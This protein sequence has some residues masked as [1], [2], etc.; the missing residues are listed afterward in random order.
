M[1]PEIKQQISD[2]KK[3]LRLAMN[4]IVSAHQRKQ[5]LDYKINFGVEI[6]RLKDIARRYEKDKE[7][8][9]TLWCDNIR[10]CKMLAIFLM[11]QEEFTTNE[12]EEWIASIRY[13][14]LADHLVMCLLSS[15][16]D[17]AENALQWIERDNGLFPYCGFLLLSHT[18]RKG[19][20]LAVEQEK[21]YLG[22]ITKALGTKNPVSRNIQSVAY[23]SLMQYLALDET[24]NKAKLQEAMSGMQTQDDNILQQIAR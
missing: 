6:P 13:T 14:E 1:T 22:H 8:A 21:K 15:R 16:N 19:H 17:A 18:F 11:P 9:Q 2:I 24:S 20:T 3:S 5:G 10:E 12:A 23:T 4:G 7:L